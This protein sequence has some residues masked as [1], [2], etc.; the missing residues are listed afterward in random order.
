VQKRLAQ[1]QEAAKDLPLETR[2][3]SP[4]EVALLQALPAKSVRFKRAE[5]PPGRTLEPE[6]ELERHK[7]PPLRFI[8][9]KKYRVGRQG[10]L[11]CDFAVRNAYL[12][13]LT[14]FCCQATLYPQHGVGTRIVVWA[15]FEC[16]STILV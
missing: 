15:P 9:P 6:F 10:A 8:F 13:M 5:S 11:R 7:E 3:L 14:C 16:R 12:Y 1:N 2:I 4:R